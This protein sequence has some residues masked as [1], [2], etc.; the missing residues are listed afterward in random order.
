[1]PKEVTLY[2]QVKIELTA[3]AVS[4]R[5]RLLALGY[6]PIVQADFSAHGGD[7]LEFWSSAAGNVVRARI[8]PGGNF[9]V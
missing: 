9:L 2:G 8:T 5:R 4:Q 7:V 3:K 6:T 1:M